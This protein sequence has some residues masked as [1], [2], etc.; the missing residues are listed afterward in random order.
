M[1]S[2]IIRTLLAPVE[3]N[4]LA[5]APSVRTSTVIS[6]QFS[7]ETPLVTEEEV[8]GKPLKVL[9]NYRSNVLY[10]EGCVSVVRTNPSTTGGHGYGGV[11][12]ANCTEKARVTFGN[13]AYDAIVEILV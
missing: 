8:L 5:P 9:N 13:K 6:E 11:P 2:V 10:L 1:E 7:Q 4:Q 12:V 3:L